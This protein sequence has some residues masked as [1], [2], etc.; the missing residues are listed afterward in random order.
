MQHATCNTQVSV[1]RPYIVRNTSQLSSMLFFPKSIYKII[2]EVYYIGRMHCRAVYYHFYSYWAMVR[3]HYLL[4]ML[5]MINYVCIC[6]IGVIKIFKLY[7]ICIRRV[8]DVC[9]FEP[10]SNPVFHGYRFG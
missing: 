6:N 5:Q 3:Q 4:S 10:S 8:G 1:W 7:L 2:F 9:V